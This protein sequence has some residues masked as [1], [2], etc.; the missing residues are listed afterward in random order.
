MASTIERIVGWARALSFEDVPEEVRELARA[1]RRSV[2]AAVAASGEDQAA[3]RVLAAIAED[4]PDGPAPLVSSARRVRA[5]EAIYGASALSIALDFDDYLCFGHS[6]HSAVLVPMMLAAEAGASGREQLLA[7]IIANEI[8]ARLGGA[9][10]IGP[11]NGQL[12]SFIHAAGTALAAGRLLGLDASRLAHALAIALYQAPRPTVPGF[13]APDSKLLTAAE[14]TMIGLRAARL[15]ARGVTGPLDALDHP[16]GFL[17]AFAFTPLARMLEQGG[18]WA[19]RTLCIKPYPGCAY[20]D[21]TLDAMRAIGPLDAEAI[22]SIEVHAGLLTCGMDGLSRPYAGD[23]PTPVTVTFSV[24]WNVAIAILAGQVTAREV[25]AAWLGERAAE[26][27]RLAQR[28]SLRHDP[29]L[30]RRT[31]AAFAPVLAPRAV[32]APVA[33]GTLVRGFAAMRREHRSVALRVTDLPALLGLLAG[34]GEPWDD[35]ALRAFA[36][37]FPARV[38]IALKGG[39]VREAE[40]DVPRGG[41]GHLTEGPGA[42][43]KAKLATNGPLLFGA[44]RTAAIDRAIEGDADELHALLR[45]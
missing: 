16:H 1:Q 23:A 28:V 11:L 15:A 40:V 4:A 42:V 44:E 45:A 21:T 10:L 24:R 12:W 32:L 18:G 37:T 20:V 2:L 35:A 3:R 41:A 43:A 34:A 38:R 5:E 30:T 22:E 19:S 17:S 29:E 36:M 25:S 26:L 9:C 13:M 31:L 6:G 7:Q 27:S 8:E 33:K 39:G 14:P